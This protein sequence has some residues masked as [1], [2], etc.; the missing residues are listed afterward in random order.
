MTVIYAVKSAICISEPTFLFVVFL[1]AQLGLN[2]VYSQATVCV[3]LALLCGHIFP[4][5]V[6]VNFG[7]VI[8]SV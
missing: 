6:S 7:H 4:L 2:F 5:T 3:P 8:I 1:G